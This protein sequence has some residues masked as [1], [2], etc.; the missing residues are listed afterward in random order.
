MLYPPL[1]FLKTAK[2]TKVP[3]TKVPFL[4]FSYPKLKKHQARPEGPLSSA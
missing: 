2:S 3:S 1:H 4:L